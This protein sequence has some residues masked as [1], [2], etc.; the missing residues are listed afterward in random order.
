MAVHLSC[1]FFFQRRSFDEIHWARSKL[2]RT[3]LKIRISDVDARQT[4]TVENRDFVVSE[5]IEG[6]FRK[7]FL[8]DTVVI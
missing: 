6:D 8:V 2:I 5:R 3:A 4:T 1:I 7:F